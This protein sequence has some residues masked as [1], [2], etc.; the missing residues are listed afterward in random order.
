[1]TNKTHWKKTF[2]KDYLGAHDLDEGQELKAVVSHVVVRQVKDPQGSASNCNVA[3]FTEKTIKPMILNVTACKQMKRFTGSHYIED[4]KNVPIQIYAT[5][6]K[7]FGEITDALRIRDKQ[8]Q[9]TKPD[10][11]PNHPKWA[12]AVE[13]YADPK[14]GLESI[15]KFF[16]LTDDNLARLKNDATNIPSSAAEQ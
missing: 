1:M 8:P 6:V 13:A 14:R 4:W 12:G 10:L 7:A 5:E 2:N 11:H 3:I 9:M 16:N 15:Q